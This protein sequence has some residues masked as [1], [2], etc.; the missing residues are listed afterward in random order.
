MT[1]LAASP[2]VAIT[3]MGAV[4]ALGTGCAALWRAVAEGRDGLRP[5]ARF[6]TRPFPSAIA[7]M[8]PAWDQRVEDEGRDLMAMS[9]RFPVVEMA[10]VAADEALAGAAIPARLAAG[11]LDP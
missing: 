1:S 11:A 8:W 10:R 3:G 9:L 4:S 2:S 7:G 5:A 6:D